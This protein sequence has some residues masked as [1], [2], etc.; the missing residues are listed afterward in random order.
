MKRKT[1]SKKSSIIRT[2]RTRNGG[3]ETEAQHFG[4]IRSALR[5]LTRFTW[6]PK[7][8]ALLNAQQISYSGK[9]KIM[10][11]RCAVCSGLYTA[12]KVEV[13]HIVPVGSLKSYTDLAGFCERLFVEDPSLLR[14]VCETCHQE[15]TNE[16]RR[17]KKL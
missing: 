16:A 11:Y 8:T 5:S 7:K 17:S 9:K 3:T 10:L 14:V 2:P 1:T 13:D 6:Q 15:I 4:K 12:K